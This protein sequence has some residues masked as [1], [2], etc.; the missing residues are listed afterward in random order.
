MWI[1]CCHLHE[2]RNMWTVLKVK[3]RAVIP[4]LCAG[5]HRQWD[6]LSHCQ[7]LRTYWD[8][9]I[10]WL[11]CWCPISIHAPR[12]KTASPQGSWERHWATFPTFGPG[13]GTLKDTDT[14]TSL[15]YLS[16]PLPSVSFSP[17]LKKTAYTHTGMSDWCLQALIEI[18]TGQ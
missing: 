16:L 10:C 13:L 9:Q 12:G 3:V 7:Q 1:S 6:T 18:S 15:F 17:I 2:T 11:S 4:R 8:L 5:K 14:H